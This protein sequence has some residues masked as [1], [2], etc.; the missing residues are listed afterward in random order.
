[1]FR[2]KKYISPYLG[3]MV[4]T[5]LIK[6]LGSAVANAEFKQM[7]SSK[8]YVSECYAKTIKTLIPYK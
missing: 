6:L 4:L 7:D 8:L 3:Y 5:L 1:M 2:L